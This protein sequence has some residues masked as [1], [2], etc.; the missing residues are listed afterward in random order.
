MY[1]YNKLNLIPI[2]LMS[3]LELF[4]AQ[5]IDELRSFLNKFQEKVS[6]RFSKRRL[7]GRREVDACQVQTD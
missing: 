4:Y 1:V 6:G 3:K 7:S 2:N 5:V